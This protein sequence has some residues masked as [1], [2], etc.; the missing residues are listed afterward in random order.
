MLK[1]QRCD[2]GNLSNFFPES[3]IWW[4]TP[5]G[6]ALRCCKT[7]KFLLSTSDRLISN[8]FY[9]AVC[10][11]FYDLRCIKSS[12][13]I[14]ELGAI[15]LNTTAFIKLPGLLCLFGDHRVF[16]PQPATVVGLPSFPF[17]S[18]GWLCPVYRLKVWGKGDWRL[19]GRQAPYIHRCHRCRPT[20]VNFCCDLLGPLR[21]L[22]QF[23]CKFLLRFVLLVQQESD[24]PTFV[25]PT[26]HVGPDKLMQY[27]IVRDWILERSSSLRWAA[28]RGDRCRHLLMR[29]RH[30]AAKKRKEAQ[31][32]IKITDFLKK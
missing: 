12:L 21:G 19:A 18:R 28:G 27:V 5:P 1:C 9:K 22:R 15:S 31:K 26:R 2:Y 14:S 16:S 8:S 32:Q 29:W 25:Y 3:W 13:L 23:Y 11:H 6:S 10:T 24:Y 4:C 17:L 20:H 30:L 7:F